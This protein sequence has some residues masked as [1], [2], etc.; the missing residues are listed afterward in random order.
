MST[1]DFRREHGYGLDDRGPNKQALSYWDFFD[2]GTYY[3]DSPSTDNVKL[4]QL[5]MLSTNPLQPENPCPS[6]I[7]CTYSVSFEAPS[8]KCE[9]R[10]DFGGPRTYNLTSMAAFG[11]LLYAS[12][13]S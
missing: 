12:Y 10:P 1:P 2:N 13:S 11:N 6:D 8:Y 7:N 5:T 4:F 9:E 3:Y